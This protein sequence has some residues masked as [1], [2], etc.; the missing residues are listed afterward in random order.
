MVSV[1][2]VLGLVLGLGLP[3]A[4]AT[5]L[6]PDELAVA[7]QMRKL[8]GMPNDARAQATKDL[9][10]KIR[11]LPVTPN[12]VRLAN[13]L[14]SLSTEGDF[15]RATLQEVASTLAEALRSFPIPDQPL[16]SDPN[17]KIPALPY[18]ELAQ[19]ARYEHV[20]VPAVADV[21]QFREAMAKLQEYDAARGRAD[22]T[23][24]DLQGKSWTLKKLHGKVVVVNF[25]ATWCPP[26]RKEMP[27]LDSLYLQFKDKGLIILAISDEPAARVSPFIAANNIHYP[28]LLDPD[29]SVHRMFQVQGI[30]KS[31][32]YDRDGKLVTQSID[33]RTRSQFLSML[34]EA[35]LH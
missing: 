4:N 9:A 15:G 18:M 10:L 14:A 11:N 5:G 35:G 20:D 31:F 2:V 1:A 25:W 26:C 21:P 24:T 12:K 30:P 6:T 17:I 32:V 8:R 16:K 29:Q 33:M 27:D 3:A 34:A 13:G 23:L 22:F 28:V 7:E 19:L